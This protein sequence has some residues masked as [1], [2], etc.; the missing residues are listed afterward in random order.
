MIISEGFVM[1][2]RRVECP[3]NEALAAFLVLK[4][5]EYFQ[6]AYSDNL[7]SVFIG[8]HKSVC[9]SRMP[10]YSLR[11]VSKLKQVSRLSTLFCVLIAPLEISFNRVSEVRYL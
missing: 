9:E 1:E 6:K 8:A 7:D 4:R 2:T 3:G 10:L 5:E 11:E